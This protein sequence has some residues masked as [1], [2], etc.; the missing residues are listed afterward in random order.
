M[1]LLSEVDTPALTVDLDRVDRNI[2]ALQGYCDQHGIAFRPHVKTHKLPQ[3]AHRQLEAGASGIACQKLGE[4]EVMIDAGLL[5]VLVTFPILGREKLKRLATLAGRARIGV[6]GDSTTVIEGVSAALSAEGVE[7]EF[8]VDCDTGLGRTGVQTAEEA[9]DLA[10]LAAGLPGLRFAGLLT[11]PTTS[12]TG[13]RMRAAVEAIERRGIVVRRVSGGGTPRARYTH[14]LDVVTELRAGTYVYGDRACV[15]NGSVGLDDCAL[16]IVATVVSRPTRERAIVD[17]GSKALTMDPA[18][19]VEGFGTL[20]EYP[21]ASIYALNEE[22]GFV[23][24]SRCVSPPNIGEVVT[25]VPNHACAAV[26]LHDE[27]VVHRSGGDI[28][29][30]PIA[31]RGRSR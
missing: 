11:Y 16:H 25:I 10:A 6:I 8:L 2:A 18:A 28:D 1:Y 31:A 24:V 5:D 9:A 4:A 12:D 15:S 19:G 29:R 27:V 21:N 7:A 22:H 3:L 30:W 23:D 13:P 26:N 20:L 14:E 17:A